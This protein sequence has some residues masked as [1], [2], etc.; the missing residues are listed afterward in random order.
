MDWNRTKTI[1]I[2]VFSILNVFLYG[3][4]LDRQMSVGNMQIIGKTSIE[5]TLAL[6]NITYDP[7]PFTKKDVSYLS[8]HIATFTNEKLEK[9]NNQSFV[10]V[11]KSR[12]LSQMKKPV[13]VTEGEDGYDFDEFLKKYVLNG[14]DYVLWDVDEEEQNAVFFQ[15][16][17][18]ETI[19]HS[20]NAMLVMHWDK[21]GKVTHYEQSMLDEFLSFNHKKDLLSQND[22]VSSL[23]TRGYLK[24]D[25]TVMQVKSGYSTLVQLTETQVFAPTWNVQ[26]KLKD[27]TIEH[28][29]INAIEGKVIEFQSDIVEEPIE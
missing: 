1:F 20:P 3:L 6:E 4:Y 11:E 24:P 25:S 16:V 10:L 8:A 18:N 13:K 14:E 7:I 9:L 17:K 12:L 15:R 5:E 29:F 27:G 26:V 28:Y 23:V 22:A 19:F 2:I 21:D